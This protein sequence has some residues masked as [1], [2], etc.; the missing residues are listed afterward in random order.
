ML[1]PLRW[2]ARMRAVPTR[3]LST[4]AT[5]AS[6]LNIPGEPSGPSVATS[7]F[8]GPQHQLYAE[9]L[10]QRT[11]NL[12]IKFPVDM[13]KSIGNYIADVDGNLYLDVFMNISST[14]MGYNH[15][16]VLAVARS[17]EMVSLVANR[18]AGGV[19][20]VSEMAELLN[21]A[22]FAEGVAPAGFNRVATAV[23]GSTAVE[24]AFKHA[25]IAYAQRKRGGMDV[26]P[27]EEEFESCMKNQG[28][29]S[30]NY[31]ILS[32]NKGFHGRMFG[33]LSTTR[34][35][36]LHK[37]DI[38]AFDWPAADPPLYKFPMDESNAV[39]NNAQD[40]AALARIRDQIADVRAQKGQEVAAVIMEPI[41]SEGG[42]NPFSAR[43]SQGIRTLTKELGIFMIVDEVQT[44]VCTSGTYWAHE[45]W[46]LDSPPDFMTFAK[47]V[48]EWR[49]V[50]HQ[51]ATQ[52]P[53][54]IC[55]HPFAATAAR[56]R[57]ASAP[58]ICWL[59]VGL[60]NE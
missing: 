10:G 60:V 30:P 13:S 22:F 34:T 33:C 28:P 41:M 51:R 14:C 7:S 59:L 38:P 47:K 15:P 55:T 25:F 19:H 21:K 2:G 53:P 57:A 58:I 11:C 48:S 16:D 20:P 27:T 40:D 49:A 26:T 23:C 39:Y 31:A 52:D 8:P 45:Q 54:P 56:S 1:A 12:A 24:A 3:P 9:Q 32:F 46:G 37:V 17:E 36:A 29:G 4:A 5:S 50:G 18:T 6:R 35:T 43:F 42:D 44:G